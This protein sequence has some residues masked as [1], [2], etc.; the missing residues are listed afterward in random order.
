MVSFLVKWPKSDA[1][2]LVGEIGSII[3]CTLIITVKDMD[4]AERYVDDDNFSVPG[5]L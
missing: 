5:L 1:C 4:W 2:N 3:V